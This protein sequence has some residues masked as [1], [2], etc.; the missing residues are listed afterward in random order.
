MVA[1]IAGMIWRIVYARYVMASAIALGVDLSLFMILLN[2]G[3]PPVPASAAGYGTGLLA[4]WIISSRLVFARQ[5]PCFV[6]RKRRQKLLF[7][8][9]AL[10]GLAVTGAIVGL[11]NRLGLDA[12]LAKLGAIAVSF[13]L[14]YMLRRSVVFA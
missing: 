2:A 11:G 12:R 7:V 8:A 14:T 9:S 13:H 1:Q 10:V 4:H 6:S 3:M 5:S